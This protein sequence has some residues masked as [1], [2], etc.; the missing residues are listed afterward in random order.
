MFEFILKIFLDHFAFREL[1]RLI[2]FNTATMKCLQEQRPLKQ[3]V[4]FVHFSE[5]MD[6]SSCFC[7]YLQLGVNIQTIYLNLSEWKWGLQKAQ[8][9]NC[10][11]RI[12]IDQKIN[13]VLLLIPVLNYFSKEQTVVAWCCRWFDHQTQEINKTMN[14]IDT[15]I[16][17]I[18]KKRYLQHQETLKRTLL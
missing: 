15:T 14:N 18:T 13:E 10:T 3:R 12:C 16:Q 4:Q 7:N 17:Q 9:G 1:L 2:S 11:P 6:V 8:Q 5:L